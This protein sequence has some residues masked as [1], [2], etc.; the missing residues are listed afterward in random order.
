MFKRALY[1]TAWLI[2]CAGYAQ[3]G[4][5][6][7]VV[8]GGGSGGGAGV[9][10]LTSCADGTALADNALMRADGTT[11]CQGSTVA[12]ADSTGDLQWEGATADDFEG[13]FTFADPTADWTWAWGAAGDLVGAGSLSI[14]NLKLDGNTLSSTD[15][16]GH[17]NLTPNGTGQVLIKDGSD[18]RPSIAFAS[19]TGSGIAVYS[20]NQWRIYSGSIPVIR[21]APGAVNFENSTLDAGVVRVSASAGTSGTPRVWV[22]AEVY[23]TVTNEG[24]TAANYNTLPTAASGHSFTFCVQDA[25]GIRIT[26]GA[27]DTI[28]VIDKV[29][30]A[31][32][33]IES[34]TIGSCVSLIA[35]NAVEWFATAVHGT[36]TD[37]TFTYD[38]T[39]L[40]T[41]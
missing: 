14:D 5:P 18:A 33:Y 37:G 7:T 31:A 1:V 10:G 36:W 16:N 34:T 29:T 19:E 2:S 11:K 3:V 27:S 12:V 17:I 9:T 25:D 28:R 6:G 22:A 26:A 4:G 30:A 23:R 41:P 35:I 40:T 38:D 15:T 8:V 24:V 39:S 32:G 21:F 13:N 20:G